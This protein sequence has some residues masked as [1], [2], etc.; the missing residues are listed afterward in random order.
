MSAICYNVNES[1]SN[2]ALLRRGACDSLDTHTR[3][4]GGES[5][6]RM[7]SKRTV[8][9]ALNSFTPLFKKHSDCNS[10]PQLRSYEK[11]AHP[12]FSANINTSTMNGPY[13]DYSKP[14]MCRNKDF[15][16]L[17]WKSISYLSLTNQCELCL[18]DFSDGVKCRFCQNTFCEE[19]FHWISRNGARHGEDGTARERPW[20]RILRGDPQWFL[21][22]LAEGK[23]SG[24]A[25]GSSSE[26]FFN[27]EAQSLEHCSEGLRTCYES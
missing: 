20:A 21:D 24:S 6:S 12:S 17:R 26:S 11:S 16:N 18:E 14:W 2:N 23:Q 27:G 7:S 25:L 1:E 4:V 3:A 22:Q 5:Q 10:A 19:C 13:E 9:I 15:S 8:S